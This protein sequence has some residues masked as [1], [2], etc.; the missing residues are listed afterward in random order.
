MKSIFFFDFDAIWNQYMLAIGEI[1]DLP[2][3]FDAFDNEYWVRSK[4]THKKL[5]SLSQLGLVGP[6][7][8]N[9]KKHNV[10]YVFSLV[11][12]SR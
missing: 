3:A 12:P 10:H 8:N 1:G 4:W 5:F 9:F 6:K 11:P 7:N 2:D